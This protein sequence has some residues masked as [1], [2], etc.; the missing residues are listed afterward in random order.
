[1]DGVIPVVVGVDVGGTNTDAVV[2]SKV[3]GQGHQILAEDKHLTTSDVTKGVRNAVLSVLRRASRIQRGGIAVRQINI[4]TTHFVN[5]VVQGRHLSPVSVIRLCGPAS[6]AVPPFADFPPDLR[7]ILCGSVHFVNGGYRV[8][9]KVIE[10]VDEGEI[11]AVVDEIR[12]KGVKG[13]VVCGIFS[14]TR[15]EQEEKVRTLIKGLYPEASV[16]L[17]HTTGHIGLLERENAAILNEALKAL[18]QRTVSAFRQALLDIGLSC[19]L[20]LTQNDGTVITDR[21]ALETPVF[22]FASGPT[23]SMRGAAYLCDLQ[24]AVVVDIGGTTTDVGVLKNGFPRQASA[25]VRVGGVRTNFRMPDVHSVGLG[26]GSYVV[27]TQAGKT[28]VGPFSAGYNLTKEAL[29][30]GTQTPPTAPQESGRR[31]TATDVAVA[32]GFMDLGDSSLVAHLP[33]DTI[34]AALLR[35]RH[36]VE[37]AIDSVRV[38]DEPLPLILVGGGSKL[39]DFKVKMAGVSEVHLP[40][41]YG[42][43][44][45]IGAALSQVSGGVDSVVALEHYLDTDTLD[46]RVLQARRD[47]PP[48]ASQEQI[49]AAVSAARKPL[50][51]AARDR[52]V[53][54]ACDNARQM[55]LQA[56]ADPA[57]LHIVDM[58]EVA[59][60]YLPGCATRVKQDHCLLCIKISFTR[61]KGGATRIKVKAVGDLLTSPTRSDDASGE[62]W[63]E[64]S[65]IDV[66]SIDLSTEVRKQLHSVTGGTLD[67]SEQDVSKGVTWAGLTPSRPDVDPRTGEWTLSA[68]DVE[69]I[70]VGAGFL[71]AGGGGSAHIGRVCARVLVE[72]GKKLRII[73]PEKLVARSD[74]DDLLIAVG[75]MGAP[76]VIYE[77]LMSGQEMPTAYRCLQELCSTGGYADGDIANKAG[78]EVKEKD[79]VVY[80]DDYQP[81]TA[82]GRG[83]GD[84]TSA[85][86]GGQTVG[87]L[88]AEVGGLNCIEPLLVSA[89]L[90][91]PVVDA[92]CMGRAFPMLQMFLPFI[93]GEKPYPAALADDKGRRAA[94]LRA[95]TPRDVEDHFRGVVI[96]MGSAGGLAVGVKSSAVTDS[97]ILRSYS[98]VWAIGDSILRARQKKE[99]PVQGLL[100]VEDVKALIVGKICDVTRETS[101]GFNRGHVRV[102]GVTYDP[103]GSGKEEEKGDNFLRLVLDFQNENLVVRQIDEQGTELGVLATVPDIITIVD[104]VTVEPLATEEV[105][106][107]QRVMVLVLP[108]HPRMATP[109]A[110]QVVGPAAFG[111][112][113]A[114]YAPLGHYREPVALAPHN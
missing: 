108:S 35:I 95:D 33:Q 58:E 94:I 102:E 114:K 105:R 46:T 69:C 26:G 57:A 23:N 10:S 47:L 68:W 41:H 92:D 52:A 97:T 111:Y 17:S 44:N 101:G 74:P 51:E 109:R 54:E 16:T 37:E 70:A 83:K 107:G 19:P 104:A 27:R 39:L 81:V 36:I 82:H 91:L 4:G 100:R 15:T 18:S 71:G 88:C 30:F 12:V 48:A 53:S 76:V 24:D 55:A 14:P 79:S 25:H 72:S 90:G 31:L 113:S 9:G 2:I 7:E 110:L 63:T 43:A 73:A 34:A 87:L 84:A 56:G 8:E 106:Y 89:V 80:I 60:S 13:I 6:R 93:H 96:Q 32:A 112:S 21:Q 85:R 62:A 5:A 3:K 11:R 66:L 78:V 40:E 86:G 45:A 65:G 64:P 38:S 59:L 1:M 103:T 28:L 29:V 75:Y 49:D 61:F 50:L 98:R 20:F 77:Q 99:D 42:V 22:I 67:P